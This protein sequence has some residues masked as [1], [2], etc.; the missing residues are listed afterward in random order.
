MGR[1]DGTFLPAVT[2]SAPTGA[3]ILAAGDFNGDNTLDLAVAANGRLENYQYVGGGVTLLL[4]NGNGTFQT[5]GFIAAQFPNSIALGDFDG[6]GKTDLAAAIVTSY[7]FSEPSIH[8]DGLLV[9]HGNGDGTLGGSVIYQGLGTATVSAV[10]TGDLNGDGDHKLDLA[11][12]TTVNPS[13]RNISVY[14]G[15]GDGTFQPALNSGGS[16]LSTPA[17]MALAD[18]NGDGRLD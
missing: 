8:N 16:G 11:V 17:S 14:V 15:N 18:L 12:T 13:F 1:G 7:D 5:A 10:V 9:V 4:G 2:S 3:S 6:D